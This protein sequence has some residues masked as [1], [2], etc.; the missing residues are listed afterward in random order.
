MPELVP[1]REMQ[2]TPFALLGRKAL[3]PCRGAGPA[4]P[5]LL[6]RTLQFRYDLIHNVRE[7][8]AARRDDR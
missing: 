8:H 3:Q 7:P 1:T 4:H 5:L 2:V 6:G